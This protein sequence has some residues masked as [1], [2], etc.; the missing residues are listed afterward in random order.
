MGGKLLTSFSYSP[1]SHGSTFVPQ[2][3][4]SSFSK[5]LSGTENQRRERYQRYSDKFSPCPRSDHWPGP[6]H[7]MSS[8][9]ARNGD[10]CPPYLLVL[11]RDVWQVWISWHRCEAHRLKK[12]LFP[13]RPPSVRCLQECGQIVHPQLS[14]VFQFEH[15]FRAADEYLS[16]SQGKVGGSFFTGLGKIRERQERSNKMSTKKEEYLFVIVYA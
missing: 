12:Y 2:S 5:T 11:L 4:H 3:L 15:C 8:I 13:R 10:F 14:S 16:P 6:P 9:V 7:H 1:A